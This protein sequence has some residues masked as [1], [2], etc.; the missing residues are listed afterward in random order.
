[1][2]ASNRDLTYEEEGTHRRKHGDTQGIHRTLWGSHGVKMGKMMGSQ[3]H[4]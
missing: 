3:R 2:T 1:M 4:K